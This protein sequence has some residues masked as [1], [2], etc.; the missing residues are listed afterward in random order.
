MKS[1]RHFLRF[2][3]LGAAMLLPFSTTL[4][5]ESKLEQALKAFNQTEVKGYIQPMA[6][7]FGAN[8]SAGWYHSA[9]IPQTGFNL[10]V[11]IVA[12][13]SVVGDDQKSYTVSA[14]AGY[15]P[16]TFQ[17]S[18]VF[19]G[20]KTVVTDQATG[21]A[22]SGVADGALNTTM[23]PLATLQLHIGSFY[24]TEVILRGLPIPEVSGAPKVSFFGVGARHSVSQ[25]LTEFPVDIAAGVF[26]NT[27]SFGDLIDM[28]SIAFGAQASKSFAVLELYGGFAYESSSMK[29]TYTAAGG[30]GNVDVTLD[31]E[32]SFRATLGLG[33]NLAVL[34]IYGDANFGTVTNF[35]AGLGFGF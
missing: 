23:F 12:M 9:A 30:G 27:I 26:W 13:G 18:T 4:A 6:D 35:S 22:Y 19:G 28:N 31:G 16:A 34:H 7:F 14:P 15:N 8:M 10:S 33:L 25:Y 21:L 17:S 11:N 2:A 29:L 1:L 24:G 32:N 5:D 20:K 3:S